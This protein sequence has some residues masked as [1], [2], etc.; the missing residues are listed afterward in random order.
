MERVPATAAAILVAMLLAGAV[1]HGAE[2]TREGY[3]AAVEPICK[4]DREASERILRGTKDKIRAG[5]L[6]VAGRQLIRA[7]ERFGVTIDR[8]AEVP[9]P[10]ADEVKLQRWLR[11]L[12]IVKE[13]LRKTGRFYKEGD[14]LQA[15]HESIRAE[16]SGNAAN[17][18]GFA[19][20]F[21]YCRLGR[22]RIG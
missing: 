5:R 14:R 18:V 4:R 10:T 13:R 6:A 21:R 15:T 16:K 12:R 9:R 8:L 17:N 11:F 7:S 1:A 19:F 22:S 3:V 20:G 2:Q